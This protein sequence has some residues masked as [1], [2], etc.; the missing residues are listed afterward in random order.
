MYWAVGP[1]RPAARQKITDCFLPFGWAV[2]ITPRPIFVLGALTF[3]S[4]FIK[5]V[6]KYEQK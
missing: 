2:A 5:K 4:H 6:I 1:D 3:C